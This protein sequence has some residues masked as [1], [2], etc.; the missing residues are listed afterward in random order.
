MS[1]QPRHI[2]NR[3]TIAKAI[4]TNAS[5]LEGVRDEVL[6]HSDQISAILDGLADHERRLQAVTQDDAFLARLRW[7]LTGK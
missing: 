6:K 7:L 5:V 4:D 1:P 2:P 3:R